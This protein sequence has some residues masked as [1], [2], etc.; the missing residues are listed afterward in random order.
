M[1]IWWNCVKEFF[2]RYTVAFRHVEHDE[3]TD[4][5][6]N[7]LNQFDKWANDADRTERHRTPWD[8][9]KKSEFF[10]KKLLCTQKLK[11]V[12]VLS[13]FYRALTFAWTWFIR[14]PVQQMDSTFFFKKKKN[15]TIAVDDWLMKICHIGDSN[16][17]EWENDVV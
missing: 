7:I 8:E 13:H 5:A 12:G 10:Y 4:V 11:C 16:F 9:K 17:S 15:N 6:I 2:I 3:I 14:T 1:S